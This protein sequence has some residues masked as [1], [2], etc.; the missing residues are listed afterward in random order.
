MEFSTLMASIERR[1]S[2]IR[3]N[4]AKY[5]AYPGEVTIVAVS[6][7]ATMDEIL[8]LLCIGERN[9]AENRNHQF[10]SRKK[11][12]RA[13]AHGCI[14]EIEDSLKGDNASPEA[15]AFYRKAGSPEPVWHFIGQ[16][17]HS[18]A[19]KVVGE[20]S[21]IHSV[22]SK[23]LAERISRVALQKGIVQDILLETNL[24]G[25]KQKQGFS[26]D[27]LMGC[28]GEISALKGINVKGLMTMAPFTE[29]TSVQYSVFKELKEL[30]T[31]LSGKG[32]LLPY[33]SMGMSNDYIEALKAGATHLRIG[34]A[35]FRDV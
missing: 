6:K 1:L 8:A 11:M 10:L 13:I 17:H 31:E 29:D 3:E 22:H 15:I 25:E 18:H 12:L 14:G 7:S 28:I 26:P 19:N 23:S 21:L 33:L 32:Y 5:K 30:S 4:I 35:L 16:L 20:C 2:L 34:T 24:S 9:L 27:E